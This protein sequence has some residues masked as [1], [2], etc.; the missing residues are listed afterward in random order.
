M[1]DKKGDLDRSAT[2]RA[3]SEIRS[4]TFSHRVASH[5][6][7][8]RGAPLKT[9]AWEASHRED[10]AQNSRK[11]CNVSLKY[12]HGYQLVPW[13][14]TICTNDLDGNLMHKHKTKNF[15]VLGELPA[16]KNIQIS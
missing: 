13:E 5:A 2:R 7:V 15:Y 12:R 6:G 11:I 4:E 3:R 16:T 14:F 1:I 10:K 9:P 8:F